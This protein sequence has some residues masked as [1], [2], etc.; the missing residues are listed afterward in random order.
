MKATFPDLAVGLVH[1]RMKPDEKA[2][3]M[4]DFKAR[5]VQ[6][7]VATTVI[8]VGVDV[9]ERDA[10]GDRARRAHGARAAAPAARARG[11][12]NGEEPRD[13]PVSSAVVGG[14]ARGD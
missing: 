1:G 4:A 8:E 2:Q 11:A 3:V 5:R 10:H 13:P 14:G 9:P 7:L 12:R 6:L